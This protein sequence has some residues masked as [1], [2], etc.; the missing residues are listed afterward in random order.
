MKQ[1]LNLRN[2]IYQQKSSGSFN[3]LT[4]K[5]GML[6]NNRPDGQTGIAQAAQIKKAMYRAEKISIVARGTAMGE[7]MSEMEED[8]CK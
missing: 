6:I 5:D 1:P 3:G 7:M 4:V 8:C 2:S